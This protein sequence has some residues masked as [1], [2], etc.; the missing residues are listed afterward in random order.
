MDSI[1]AAL[2][3]WKLDLTSPN[4]GNEVR[5]LETLL[6]FLESIGYNLKFQQTSET[7][8]SVTLSKGETLVKLTESDFNQ[9]KS[10]IIEAIDFQLWQRSQK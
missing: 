4:L 10:K 3:I 6:K 2:G 9:I 5:K 8:Y 1:A 7:S